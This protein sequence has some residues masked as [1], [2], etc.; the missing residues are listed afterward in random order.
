LSYQD[1]TPVG[2]LVA[3]T[4]EVGMCW[5]LLK[6][7]SLHANL[8]TLSSHL[9]AAAIVTVLEYASGF[10]GGFFLGGLTDVP[11]L[12]FRPVD[13]ASALRSQVS[14]RF[15]RLHQ[16]SL[17]WGIR[18]ETRDSHRCRLR[19]QNHDGSPKEEI[20][21]HRLSVS[22]AEISA[23][24]GGMHVACRVLRGGV[25]DEWNTLLGSMAAGAFFRRK[26]TL[27]AIPWAHKS[28]NGSADLLL[29]VGKLVG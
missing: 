28:V 17:R 24:C 21:V 9:F 18:Y 1:L 6:P 15:L 29:T 3:G 8:F 22:W 16:K 7:K 26:G 25:E 5:C 4:V 2:K 27:N 14:S 11:R 10:V 19:A 13:G 12:L 20:F 23:T